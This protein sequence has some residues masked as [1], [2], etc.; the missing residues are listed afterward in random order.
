MK[1]VWTKRILSLVFALAMLLSMAG[2]G[3][4]G[5]SSN[6]GDSV[7]SDSAGDYSN[8]VKFSCTTYYSLHY[9]DAG[10]DLEDDELYKYICDKFN[11]EIDAWANSAGDTSTQ[12]WMNGGTLPDMFTMYDLSHLEVREY[13]D[14]GAIKPLPDNWK[15]QWPNLAK[16]VAASG[17]EELFTVD[18]KLYIIPHATFGNLS[19]VETVSR[20][21]SLYYRKD[22]AEAI[23]MADLGADG[24][25]TE[26]QLKEYL[27][28]VSEAGLCANSYI[29]ANMESFLTLMQALNDVNYPTFYNDG[30]GYAYTLARPE[31]LDAIA[32]M[33]QWKNEGY[34]NPNFTTAAMLEQFQNYWYG[35]IPACLYAGAVG[36][37]SNMID[38]IL[39]GKGIEPSNVEE[40]QKLWNIYG[41]AA[42]AQDDGTIMTREDDN[43]WLISGFG[44]E[45]S[46]ET[47]VRI[48]DMIDYFCTEEGEISAGLGVYGEHW[49]YGEDGKIEMIGSATSMFEVSPS[50]FFFVWGYG[51][52]VMYNAGVNCPGVYDYEVELCTKLYDVR[53]AGVIVP[54]DYNYEMMT[55]DSYRNF[56]VS[57]AGTIGTLVYNN[58][59]IASEWA[60]FLATYQNMVDALLADL[61]A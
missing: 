40:R 15:E 6:S 53:N 26:S 5:E 51:D 59:D 61:N 25:I 19:Q 41:M 33:R 35:Q 29:G 48:L 30:N 52:D 44:S 34:V 42:M 2:C 17:A 47:M 60:G 36:E 49:Q 54:L 22:W 28:K 23:G 14:M 7:S 57:P 18:G 55:T 11:V 27:T 56:S 37:Y 45:C 9:A 3:G 38:Q 13:A 20:H 4:S 21:T 46:E 43:Y 8:T 32:E 50:R 31:Y 24:V 12:V 10:Y 39:L 1:N 58:N 16:M